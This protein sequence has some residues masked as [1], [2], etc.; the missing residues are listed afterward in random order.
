MGLSSYDVVA[1]TKLIKKQITSSTGILI[2]D[3]YGYK[4]TTPKKEYYCEHCGDTNPENFGT[5]KNICK[6][7]YADLTRTNYDLADRLYSRSSKRARS[8]KLKFDLTKE[9]IE[10][11][12]QK[13]NY[14][15]YYTGIPFG[16]NFNNKDNYPT[17]DRIDSTK[18]YI[19]GN[20]CICTYIVNGMKSN[21]AID[22]FKDIVTKIYNNI[23]NF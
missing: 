16:D 19:K 1:N 9:Y 5:A 12:L 8:A 10:E 14:K 2:K 11:I 22:Q 17:I 7:C 21:L 23:N 20:I 18:G 15:C 6:K 3:E 4:I 13:Q